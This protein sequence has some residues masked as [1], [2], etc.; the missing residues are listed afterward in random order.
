M[1]VQTLFLGA[2]VSVFS[3]PAIA[4]TNPAPAFTVADVHPSPSRLHP[5]ID[6]RFTADR[7]MLRD[8]TITD[9][10]SMAYHV[11]PSDILGGPAWL[12][13]DRFDIKEKPPAGMK[14]ANEDNDPAAAAMLRALLIDRF[15]L[16]ARVDQRSLPAFALSIGKAN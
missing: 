8:A 14:I 5:G 10:I 2:V 16:V 1:K 13:F 15:A 4:Q 9:L 7:V 12:D 6:G 11:D 3:L